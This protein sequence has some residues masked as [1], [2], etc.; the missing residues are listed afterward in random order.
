MTSRVGVSA[1]TVTWRWIS[2]RLNVGSWCT[3]KSSSS[4]SASASMIASSTSSGKY[5]HASISARSSFLVEPIL[6]PI[7]L[8]RT[9]DSRV[10]RQLIAVPG[11]PLPRSQNPSQRIALVGCRR[12]EDS[13]AQHRDRADR[14]HTRPKRDRSQLRYCVR[15]LCHAMQ[16]ILDP[17]NID[18][19]ST[20]PAEK[21]RG[22]LELPDHLGGIDRRQG[23]HAVDDVAK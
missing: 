11:E 20:V 3:T 23:W 1:S 4:S 22:G 17:R 9:T 6:M 2:S 21:R 12:N 16:Q 13:R 5:P 8:P 10:H 18:A 15:K 14:G 7:I 19:R